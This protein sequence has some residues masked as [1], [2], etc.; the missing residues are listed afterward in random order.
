MTLLPEERQLVLAGSVCMAGHLSQALLV[1]FRPLPEPLTDHDNELRS[2]RRACSCVIF[3]AGRYVV[4][5]GF[6][7]RGQVSPACSVTDIQVS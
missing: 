3:P 6:H 5:P 1:K 4:W 2:V 7:H